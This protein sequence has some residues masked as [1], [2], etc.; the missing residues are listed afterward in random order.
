MHITDVDEILSNLEKIHKSYRLHKL[1]TQ[2]CFRRTDRQSR[3][4]WLSF[5]DGKI[6][7]NSP[8][9]TKIGGAHNW[10]V[11]N[12]LVKFYLIPITIVRVTDYTKYTY[13]L[14]VSI[15]KKLL[16]FSEGKIH[17]NSPNVT[18]IGGA[19]HW[20]VENVLVKF[21]LI[22]ITIVRVTDYTKY[23]PYLF[24]CPKNG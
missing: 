24:Q 4:K 7:K 9:V 14:C 16:S 3:K 1:C 13:T 19:H 23:R 20:Y 17:K 12:V 18:E 10:Y 11:E 6:R 8:N 15:S 21:Y 22:P 2:N 5:T